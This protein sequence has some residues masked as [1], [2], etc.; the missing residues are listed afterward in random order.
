MEEKALRD[1]NEEI[2]LKLEQLNKILEKIVENIKN[3]E[4]CPPTC[5]LRK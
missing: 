2:I 1:I 3:G 5:D 4:K